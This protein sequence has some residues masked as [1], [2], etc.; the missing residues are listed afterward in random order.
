MLETTA[1]AINQGEIVF[2]T[3]DGEVK[4]PCDRVIARMGSAPPRGFVEATLAE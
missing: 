4:A 1:S 2:D 3:R